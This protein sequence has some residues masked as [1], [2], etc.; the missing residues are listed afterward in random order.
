MQAGGI[1]A[2]DIATRTGWA[3]A[4]ADAVRAWPQTALQWGAGASPAAAV[5]VGVDD[6]KA[7]TPGRVVYTYRRWLLDMMTFYQPRFLV[8]E[9]AL[10]NNHSGQKA[11][12]RLLYLCGATEDA[13]YQRGVKCLQEHLGSIRKHFLGPNNKRRPRDDLKRVVL[14]ECARRGFKT[15]DDNTADAIAVLDFAAVTLGHRFR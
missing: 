5:K 6:F 9:A 8:F 7:L 13:C 1:L 3:Y 2:L 14:E 10:V 12:Q 11:A 15:D 4:P